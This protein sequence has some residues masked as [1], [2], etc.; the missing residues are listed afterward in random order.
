VKL[1]GRGQQGDGGPGDR[2]EALDTYIRDIFTQATVVERF[3]ERVTYRVPQRNVNSLSQ[4]FAALEDGRN[5]DLFIV[6][7]DS[8][9]NL[10]FYFDMFGKA[11]EN[12]HLV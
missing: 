7:L 10:C 2:F 4:T 3:G 6:I 1:D 11:Q 5:S 12:V 9:L 8:C